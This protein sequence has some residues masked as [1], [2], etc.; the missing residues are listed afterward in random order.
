[1]LKLFRMLIIRCEQ[2][3]VWEV[4]AW[5]H[6]KRTRLHDRLV[7]LRHRIFDRKT[8]AEAFGIPFC[9]LFH[10]HLVLDFTLQM[11]INPGFPLNTS[12]VF[13]NDFGEDFCGAHHEPCDQLRSRKNGWCHQRDSL[14]GNLHGALDAATKTCPW[15]LRLSVLL[16]DASLGLQLLTCKFICSADLH[17]TFIK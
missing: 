5:T 8:E 13:L 11:F 9:T 12:Q 15:V 3:W 14:V 16:H 10:S 1:M 17:L 2:I 6:D 7:K 4:I